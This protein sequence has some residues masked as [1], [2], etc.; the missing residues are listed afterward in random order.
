MNP[1]GTGGGSGKRSTDTEVATVR[2]G[3]SQERMAPAAITK[4]S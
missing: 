3:T 4:G 1:A 2:M